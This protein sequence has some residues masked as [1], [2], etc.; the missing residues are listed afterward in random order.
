MTARRR[1]SPF[2]LVIGGLDPTGGAGVAAD[3]RTLEHFHVGS[4]VV[5]TA[6]TVQDGRSVTRVRR[7]PASLM[8]EQL[9]CV[10]EALPVAAI[11][12]GML[13]S[14]TAVEVVAGFV[15]EHEIP[16][17]VDP[18]LRSSGGQPL[19]SRSALS[20]I[21]AKL[22]PLAAVATPNLAEASLLVGMDIPDV[23]AMAVAAR[24]IL[25]LGARAVVVK[26]GHMAGAPIDV[27]A[28]GRK[29]ERLVGRRIPLD[30][31]G[32]G[33]AFASALT[34]GLVHGRTLRESVR[35]AGVHVRAL[36]TSAERLANGARIRRS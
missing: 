11:K 4:A 32:T 22:L 1:A 16:L 20:A 36:M 31:H 27:F 9:R 17:V 13:P 21:R 26:G 5:V 15:A 14:A 19:A 10:L 8:R 25:A 23:D 28:V 35:A 7:V 3:V 30:M 29:V 12:C 24:R 33:C 6:L 2:V 34:A 18:V